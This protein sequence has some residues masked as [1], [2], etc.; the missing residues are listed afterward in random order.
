[1]TLGA[2][3]EEEFPEVNCLEKLGQT[4]LNYLSCKIS[5][6]LLFFGEED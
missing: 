5:Q 1:M 3:G 4:K 2:G 6:N